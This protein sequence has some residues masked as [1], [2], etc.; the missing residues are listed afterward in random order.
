MSGNDDSLKSIVIDAGSG[1]TKIG[2]NDLD[3]MSKVIPTTFSV[4]KDGKKM[5]GY[6]AISHRKEAALQRMANREFIE[7]WDNIAAFW[8]DCYRTE[9]KTEPNNQPAYLGIHNSQKKGYKEKLVQVFLEE[10]RCPGFYVSPNS[11]LSLYGTGKLAG[12]VVDAGEGTTTV[13]ASHEGL[14][15]EHQEVS[16]K[17]AGQDI[18]EIIKNSLNHRIED[19]EFIRNIK[20][21]KCKVEP[22]LYLKKNPDLSSLMEQE[23]EHSYMLPD[24][25]SVIINSDIVSAPTI[26][27]NP[28]KIGKKYLGIHELVYEC[29]MQ[30]D[31]EARR[32]LCS[33]L[34]LTGGCFHTPGLAS[35]LANQVNA[36]IPTVFRA[37][38]DETGSYQSLTC[39]GGAIVSSMTTFQ[40]NWI[41]RQML[42]EHGPSIVLRKCL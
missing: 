8:A 3:L 6:N 21:N 13:S 25:S 14:L 2:F 9:C 35:A 20:H 41:T 5:Y 30:A 4:G 17:I 22:D 39:M 36:M 16:I 37:R 15:N 28:E 34:V 38:F 26:L 27:F 18:N 40:S 24:G 12:V 29:I 32:E 33:N 11:L 1:F 10:L 19:E 23:K 42:D 31:Y 7:D